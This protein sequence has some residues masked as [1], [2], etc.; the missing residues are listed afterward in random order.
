M[1]KWFDEFVYENGSYKLVALFIT[2]ILW[3]SV[4][5]RKETTVSKE[6]P[7]VFVT[8][9]NHVVSSVSAKSVRFDLAGSKRSLKKY[10]TEKN[11]PINV[12]LSSR[13]AGR[14]I[15]S[16]P[17][18]TMRLPFG[19]KVVSINPPSI[20]IELEETVKKKVP[21]KVQWRDIEDQKHLENKI[22]I[23]PSD[24]EIEGAKSIISKIR[25]VSTV[26]VNSAEAVAE[27]NKH[28][29]RTHI[30]LPDGE[31]F[32]NNKNQEIKIIF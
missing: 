31:G 6:V 15:V 12:D 17:D 19:A 23:E 5:G 24:V 10:V 2:L 7:L 4:L 20:V 32:K 29:I 27:G 9:S 16:V 8:A 26:E 22:V 3:V 30:R 14:I 21:V 28:V 1:K 25:S 13:A 11:D 18:D